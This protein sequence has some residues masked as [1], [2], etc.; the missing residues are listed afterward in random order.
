M[1]NR[2]YSAALLAFC[3]GELFIVIRSFMAHGVKEADKTAHD[4]CLKK[5][6][7]NFGYTKH[8]TEI[9]TVESSLIRDAVLIK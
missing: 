8:Q 6:P 7:V 4:L 9:G 2:L 3:D 1:K 5:F